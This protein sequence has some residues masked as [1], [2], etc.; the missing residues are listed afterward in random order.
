MLK[1]ILFSMEGNKTPGLDRFPTTFLNKFC[2]ICKMFVVVANKESRK[3][4][5]MKKSWKST[6]LTL[7][8]K[9]EGPLY[10]DAIRPVSFC[11]TMYKLQG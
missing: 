1:V 7:I 10:S 6:F 8:P 3:K 5:K 11:N 9:K 2:N 4:G